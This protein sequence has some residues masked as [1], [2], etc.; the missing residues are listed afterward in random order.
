MPRVLV[1]GANRG[2]GFEFVRQYADAGWDVVAACRKPAQAQSLKELAKANP[3]V[4]LRALDVNDVRGIVGFARAIPGAALDLF[5]CNAGLHG[6]RSTGITD[7]AAVTDLLFQ[8]IMLTNVLG[9][10]RLIAELKDVVAAGGDSGPGKMVFLS[11]RMGSIGA[12]RSSASIIYRAS[13]A[14]LN[15]V[16]KSAAVELDLRRVPII[17]MHPGWV[18]TDMGGPS[19]DIDVATS[20]GGMRGV[21]ERLTVKD[22]GKFFDYTGG[23]IP[24]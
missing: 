8:E 9:P 11:S 2:L 4:L 13:K 16:I 15:A 1:T 17:A 19:A 24:W 6:P 10:L 3:H 22:S 5:V 21:I 20:I 23:E 12:M 7:A 18:R 14:A